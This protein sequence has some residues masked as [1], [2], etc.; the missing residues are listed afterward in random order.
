MQGRPAAV[1]MA[2]GA[3]FLWSTY[4]LFVLA[5]SPATRPSAVLWYPFVSG[6]AAYALLCVGRR[7]GRLLARTFT[8]AG[9]YLRVGLLV[10]MQLSVLAATLLTG[11]VD[12]A[13]LSLLGDVVA[14][15]LVVAALF[16]GHRR[17]LASRWL[18]TGLLLCLAG[19]ALAIV[20]GHGIAAVHGVGW[21]VVVTVPL[22]VA[23][24]FVLSARAGATTPVSVVVAQTMVGAAL[25]TAAVSP[26]VPGGPRAL[27]AVGVVPLVLLLANGLLS[28]FVAPVLYFRAIERAGLVLPPLLM[29]GIPVFTLLL[30]AAVLGIAPAPLALLGVPVAVLGGVVALTSGAGSSPGP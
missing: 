20:G 23:F 7:Q 19:G 29:T 16:V 1:V 13:L 21:T 6:A 18:V 15:P 22:S 12:A 25:V 28:F 27:L 5:V 11:P 10:G 9:A 24:Y 17:A 3:A 26:L 8:Q 4:Y 2:L 30:S 14:T